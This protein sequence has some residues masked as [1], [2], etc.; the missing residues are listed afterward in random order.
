MGMR[1]RSGI[2]FDA[3][4]FAEGRRLVLGG[5]TVPGHAG[6]AGHSDADVVCHAVMDALLGAAAEGD[7]GRHFPDRDPAWKDAV[8]LELLERTVAH[9]RARGF[10]AGNVDVTVIAEQPALAPH[11]DAMRGRLASVLGVEP[12][13]V[14]VKATTVEG[15]GALG[16]GEGIAALA[17]ATVR[18][19]AA[20]NE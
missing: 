13:R 5:V 11:A 2:G 4:R 7:I 19:P 18:E 1:I 9:L 3:H 6:L 14:S 16:R 17:V 12:G 20:H 15:M 10:E 8:S